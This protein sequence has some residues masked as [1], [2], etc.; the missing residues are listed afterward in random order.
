M[1]KLKNVNKEN[2]IPVSK[3][4][5]GQIGIIT[6]WGTNDGYKGMI[7]QKFNENLVCIGLNYENGWDNIPQSTDCRVLI[8][9]EGTELIITNNQ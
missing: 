7:I 8:I 9:G 6:E 3:L 1:V 5:D 2:S 4:R